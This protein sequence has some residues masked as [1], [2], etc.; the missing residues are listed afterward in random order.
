MGCLGAFWQATVVPFNVFFS[1][2]KALLDLVCGKGYELKPSLLI[3]PGLPSAYMFTFCFYSLHQ[4]SVTSLIDFALP[5]TSQEVLVSSMSSKLLITLHTFETWMSMS[6]YPI[7]F[8]CLVIIALLM[9]SDSSLVFT[10]VKTR[11]RK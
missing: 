6:L 1:A 5:P 11:N 7:E 9:L 8:W 10:I 3:A 2:H 4:S